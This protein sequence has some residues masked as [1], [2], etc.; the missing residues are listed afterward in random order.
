MLNM[1]SFHKIVELVPDS[2]SKLP[3]GSKQLKV[4]STG[5]V[6][7]RLEAEVF[8]ETKQER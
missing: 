7:W 8:E 1:A 4:S 5:L 3:M 6:C 2:N